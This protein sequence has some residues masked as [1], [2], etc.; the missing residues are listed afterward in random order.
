MAKLSRLV[1]GD[2]VPEFLK[3][4]LPRQRRR[5]RRRRKTN[6]PDSKRHKNPGSQS[7]EFL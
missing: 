4:P 6:H 3:A 2:N 5:W 1:L 7:I